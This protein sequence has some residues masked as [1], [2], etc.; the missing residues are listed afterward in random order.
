MRLL[1]GQ[2]SMRATR[3]QALIA[4]FRV[5]L[6]MHIK[7][8]RVNN[9]EYVMPEPLARNKRKL[10][11]MSVLDH[12]QI[13]PETKQPRVVGTMMWG[14]SNHPEMYEA[15]QGEISHIAVPPL[16]RRKGIAKRMYE[17]GQYIANVSQ[18]REWVKTPEGYKPLNPEAIN[19]PNAKTILTPEHS[20]NQ[21]P[22]GRS[23]ARSVGGY[24]PRD[25]YHN[26]DA[27]RRKQPR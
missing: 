25:D 15:G 26:Y 4:L 6:S 24:N 8:I 18:G 10:Y 9:L 13:D 27:W 21:S 19:N 7:S 5:L 2:F 23:W 20:P 3:N 11:H 12:T 14:R 22:E 17:F 16:S 1:N